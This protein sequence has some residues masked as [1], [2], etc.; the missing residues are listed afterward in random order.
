MNGTLSYQS[1]HLVATMDIDVNLA[2]D[3]IFKALIRVENIAIFI[4]ACV[5]PPFL[6]DEFSLVK[7]LDHTF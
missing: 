1:Y 2:I 6:I 7:L 4:E 5:F 3:S